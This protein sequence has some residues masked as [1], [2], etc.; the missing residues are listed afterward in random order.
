MSSSHTTLGPTLPERL[1]CD[2]EDSR[3]HKFLG[4]QLCLIPTSHR[5][6]L[7][8]ISYL[9]F[10]AILSPSAVSLCI[11]INSSSHIFPIPPAFEPMV[12]QP[13]VLSPARDEV[14]VLSADFPTCKLVVHL[15]NRSTRTYLIRPHTGPPPSKDP[16]SDFGP[17]VNGKIRLR[18][19]FTFSLVKCLP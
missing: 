16:Q 15:T 2:A 18:I 3:G 5:I 6:K 9:H 19:F 10:F 17:G 8:Q 11:E 13:L 14:A 12:R 7:L 1:L 4:T